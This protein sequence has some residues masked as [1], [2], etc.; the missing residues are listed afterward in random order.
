MKVGK[1]DRATATPLLAEALMDPDEIRIGVVRKKD[2]TDPAVQELI[3]DRRYIRA[4]KETGLLIV[5]EIGERGWEAVTAYNTTSRAG[6]VDL[7]TLD[8]RRGGKLIY[9]RPKK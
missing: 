1:H 6:R 9:Q 5:F 4:D 3:V 8:R 7:R 2:P